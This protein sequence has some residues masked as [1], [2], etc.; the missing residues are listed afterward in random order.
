MALALLFS[1]ANVFF[2]DFGKVVQTL[3]Q[4]VHVQRA[5]DLPLL[6]RRGAV[7]RRWPRYYLLN[8]VAEAVLLMQRCFWVGTTTIPRPRPSSNLPAGPVPARLRSCSL[9]S[10]V[11]LVVAQWVF[12]RLE[13]KVPERL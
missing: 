12:T 8:P 7:R 13:S 10:L 5:D 1:V 4:F 2:R 11:A 3:T 9:V 6:H